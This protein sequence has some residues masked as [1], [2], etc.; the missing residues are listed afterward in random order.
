MKICHITC[1]L[2]WC[3]TF[4]LSPRLTK[5]EMVYLLFNKLL[6]TL[7]VTTRIAPKSVDYVDLMNKSYHKSRSRFLVRLRG[8]HFTAL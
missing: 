2:P 3:V 5:P 7:Q 1:M 4:T 6:Q 8:C